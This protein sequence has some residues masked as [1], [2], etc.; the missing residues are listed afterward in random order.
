MEQCPF[1]CGKR[2]KRV[3]QNDCN[4]FSSANSNLCRQVKMMI[5]LR[6]AQYC[7]LK[8]FLIFLVIY[9]HLIETRIWESEL[10]MVQ[11]RWIYLV[12][13]PLFSFLSGL[14]INRKKDC[15]VQ[16]VRIFPLYVFL[17]IVACLIE[18][19]TVKLSTPWWHL[20]YLLSYCYWICLACLWFRFW[21][22]R[23]KFIILICSVII[24]CVAGIFP[25]IG[26]EFSL[27]RTLV[28][29][30]YFWTGVIFK[31]SF[32]WKK[33]RV[34][35]ILAFETALVIMFYIGNEIPVAFLYQAS[36]YESE[37]C[38]ALR[39]ICYV[40]S[41]LLGLFL[42]AVSPTS[43]LPF[44]KMGANTMLAYVI[45]A[46]IVLCLRELDIPWQFNIIFTVA[47]LYVMYMFTK[48]HGA[49]YG[50]VPKKRRENKWR[51]F[52]KSMKNMLSQSIDSS[53][54]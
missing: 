33:L 32:N 39:L 48:W 10:L 20:W 38:I 5:K 52:K 4:V 45:H 17:Q 18:S 26:R 34:V 3:F 1:L 25:Y 13:M 22:G 8:L 44:S 37:N 53:Y 30:P 43:R 35:G 42:L 31:P 23:C 24:G 40:L 47:F 36:P 54:P 19:G 28:F 29:F 12:H 27:S 9:G 14:F 21:E 50:I 46:P 7:N 49:L 15:R 51:L 6:E 2:N 11:Y 16:L 41:G